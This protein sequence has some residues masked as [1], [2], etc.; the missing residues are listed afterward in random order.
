M[1]NLE[2]PYLIKRGVIPKKIGSGGYGKI[3]RLYGY[4]LNPQFSQIKFKFHAQKV[5]NSPEALATE[6]MGQ[7]VLTVLTRLN[8]GKTP[9]GI[10][11][12][13]HFQRGIF[14]MKEYVD[15]NFDDWHSLS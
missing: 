12:A 15:G 11:E 10:Q 1:E 14:I 9:Q 4:T 13:P 3:Y 6:L 7:N 8:G 5:L 2:S